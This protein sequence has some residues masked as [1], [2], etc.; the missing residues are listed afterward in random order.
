MQEQV[1]KP[2]LVEL[3]DHTADIGLRVRA[4]TS[5]Q[6]FCALAEAMFD[7]LLDRE[8]V[9]PAEQW[10]VHVGAGGWE[11]LVV[12]FLE[13]LLYLYEARGLA[14]H[15]CTIT[16]IGENHLDAEMSGD[17]LTTERPERKVQIKAVTYHQ[18]R[19]EQTPRGFEI[20]VIF[21]I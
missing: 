11:D 1:N 2:T 3:I 10:Q 16:E 21:D 17:Y 13:E 15:A 20:Q 9:V 6:A 18:L 12:F 8:Q 7:I 14:V 4:S 5:H 19:A